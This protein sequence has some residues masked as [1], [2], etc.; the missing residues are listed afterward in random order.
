MFLVVIAL[1]CDVS[2]LFADLYVVEFQKRGLPHTHTLIWLKR[3]TKEPSSRLIDE[4]ISAE[5]PDPMVDPLGYVLVDE[6]MVHGPCGDL[7][8]LCPCMKNGV[9]SKRFP[10]SYNVETLVD[11]KGFPVYR[12][13]EDGRFVFRN[14]GTARLTN[15]WVVPYNLKLLKRFQAHINVEWCNKTNLMKYLFKYVTKGH[16]VARIR[17]QNVGTH[18]LAG[19][20]AS[21]SG[22]GQMEVDGVTVVVGRNEIDEYIKC[23]FV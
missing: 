11:E 1:I 7:N 18:V 6:F 8:R 5:L 13:R 16:D 20:S 4:F 2:V 23:R 22:N 9:C 15:Q 14:K 19:E 21:V 17:F 10:K 3:N 12:R